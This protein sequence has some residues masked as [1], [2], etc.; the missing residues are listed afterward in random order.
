MGSF[1]DAVDWVG[2]LF[3]S[4]GAH[5]MDARGNVTVRNNP[6]LRQ[7]VEMGVRIGRSLPGDVWAWDDGG[8]NRA[9]ISGRSALIFNPPSAWAVAKRDAPQVAEKCWTI[10][11][12]SGPEM[13]PAAYLPYFWGLWNFSRNKPA[14]KAL[15]EHLSQREQAERQTN[16]SGGYDIP[17]FPSMADFKVWETEGPPVGTVYNYP[18][19]P[20]HQ[21]TTTIAM[22]PAP[23][24]FAVQMYNN[25]FNTKLI[26]RIVQGGESIDQAL[27]WVEREL[28]VIRRGG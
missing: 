11:M 13:R 5:L 17:P 4:Y 22:A 21:S 26:A 27:G 1:T 24:D 6:K 18:Q 15:L 19:K 3:Q 12:P 9:L 20:H 8:N 25:G 2:A 28:N 16:T 10:P 23:P 14:A 7:A